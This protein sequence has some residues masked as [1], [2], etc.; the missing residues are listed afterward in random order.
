MLTNPCGE[1]SLDLMGG[2]CVISDTVPFFADSLDEAEEAFRASTRALIRVNKMNS[3]VA[4]STDDKDLGDT[5]IN[6]EKF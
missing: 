2:F 4:Y 5:F 6:E 1:I 3:I